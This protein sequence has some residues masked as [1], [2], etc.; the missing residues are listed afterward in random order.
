MP[1][2]AWLMSI[3]APLVFR[4]LAQLGIGFVTFIGVEAGV[5]AALTHAQN[6]YLGL[7]ATVLQFMA[8]AG[9][10][11]ALGILAGG[12]TARLT[13]MAMKRFQLK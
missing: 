11:S 8:I 7:P 9:V 3:S 13:L 10:N 6:V 5:N 4:V 2:A 1:I 12:I